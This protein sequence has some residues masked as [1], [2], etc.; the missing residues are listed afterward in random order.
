M[1]RWSL[2]TSD[3]ARA[4]QAHPNTV[5]LYEELGFLP[6]VPRGQNGWRRYS[7]AHL[8]QMVLARVALHGLWPGK[9]IRTSA[10]ALVRT[11]AS[12]DTA[13]ALA[14]ARAHL[15]LVRDE[16][17]RAEEA[18]AYLERWA[19]GRRRR[20]RAGSWSLREAAALVDATSEQVRN[21]E[22]NGLLCVPRAPAT[23]Y[24]VFGETELGRLRVIR[25]LLRAGYS[26]MAVLRMV[27]VLDGGSTRGLRQVL[28]TPDREE[29]ALTAFDRWLSALA[30]QEERARGMIRLIRQRR[31]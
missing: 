18:A 31:G 7:R 16:R 8:E 13:R 6:P 15:R 10:V 30:A 5:R 29:D 25:S 27:R 19:K 22:R 14:Q 24:R 3:L 23:G 17:R 1:T 9:S 28:D 4:A 20:A 11:A 12:G 21:W 26:V 2:K